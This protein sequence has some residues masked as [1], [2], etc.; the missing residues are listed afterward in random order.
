MFPVTVQAETSVEFNDICFDDIDALLAILKV[1]SPASVCNVKSPTA[2]S[3]VKFPV[4]AKIF[5]LAFVVILTA[6]DDVTSISPPT[7]VAAKVNVFPP[8]TVHDETSPDVKTSALS[9]AI[10]IP[11]PAT[12]AMLSWFDVSPEIVPDVAANPAVKNDVNPSILRLSNLF[13][14]IL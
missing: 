11:P 12:E 14:A 1:K 7:S 4:D 6:P 13:V 3:T 10:P 2:T 8:L 5:E 9:A